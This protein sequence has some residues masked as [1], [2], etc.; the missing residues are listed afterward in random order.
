MS[1]VELILAECSMNVGLELFYVSKF[2]RFRGREECRTQTFTFNV[3]YMELLAIPHTD[4]F[5]Q[6]LILGSQHTS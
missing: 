1:I 6:L 3:H 5:V 4:T 2:G